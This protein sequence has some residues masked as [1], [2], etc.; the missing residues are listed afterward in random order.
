[1]VFLIRSLPT[2]QGDLIAS[3]PASRPAAAAP[4]EPVPPPPP[5]SATPPPVESP[6]PAGPQ[7]TAPPR[8]APAKGEP[9]R[10]DP[11]AAPQVPLAPAAARLVR[12]LPDD[13][14]AVITL[15]AE[16]VVSSPL[17][18]KHLAERLRQFFKNAPM[19]QVG[20]T[21]LGFDPMKDVKA[22]TVALA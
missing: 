7:G 2:Q 21:G 3:V 1:V 22:C 9:S 19:L 11:S 14:A 13:T 15:N 4:R 10:A 8:A 5:E 12:Y 16:Q 17:F 18:K 6:P 20:F